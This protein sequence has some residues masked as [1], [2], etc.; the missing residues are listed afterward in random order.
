[1]TCDVLKVLPSPFT[2]NEEQV[3]M[4]ND[5]T[6]MI[7]TQQLYTQEVATKQTN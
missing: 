1:M 2:C 5:I 3:H 7:V 6:M 4:I